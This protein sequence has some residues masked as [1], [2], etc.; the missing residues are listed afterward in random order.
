LSVLHGPLPTARPQRASLPHTL[1]THSL[2]ALQAAVSLSPAHVLVAGLQ[3]LPM[4]TRLAALE[5]GA[6]A[7][8]GARSAGIAVPG[9]SSGA[10]LMLAPSQKRPELQSASVEQASERL[11]TEALLHTCERHTAA[12]FCVVHGPA[13]SAR[14]HLPSL[15]HTF[16]MHSLA[17]LQLVPLSAAQVSVSVLQW[18][19][20]QAA[21]TCVALEQ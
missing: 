10:Q 16:A 13:E 20:A 11:H 19:L 7:V 17:P 2:A 3:R 12:A 8:H 18:P 9:G 14:P 1:D 4:H 15:P 21:L 6:S 5:A